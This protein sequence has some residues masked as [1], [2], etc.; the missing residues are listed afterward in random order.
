MLH[1]NL[2]SSTL[3]RALSHAGWGELAGNPL[4]GARAVLLALAR[5]GGVV[6]TTALQLGDDA[7]YSER[8]VRRA[9]TTLEELGV[10][11]WHRGRRVDGRAWPSLVAIQRGRILAMIQPGRQQRAE[12]EAAQRKAAAKRLAPRV[13]RLRDLTGIAREAVRPAADAVTAAARQWGVTAREAARRLHSGHDARPS[14]QV[15]VEPNGAPTAHPVE[16]AVE[17]AEPTDSVGGKPMSRREQ[18]RAARARRQA[19]IQAGIRHL[20]R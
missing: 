20:D 7:G 16:S 18:L 5:R 10:I 2:S 15:G 17:T 4:K 12:R 1:A 8:H 11:T 3:L 6:R 13:P 19:E 9:L 14:Q